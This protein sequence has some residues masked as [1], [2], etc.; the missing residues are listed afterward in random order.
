MKY[1]I[2]FKKKSKTVHILYEKKSK[3]FKKKY[4]LFAQDVKDDIKIIVSIRK[5]KMVHYT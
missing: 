4:T 5:R 2:F 3:T 1:S